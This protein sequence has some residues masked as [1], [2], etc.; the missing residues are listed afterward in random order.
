[1]DEAHALAGLG[2]CALAVG[3][4]ADAETSLRQAREIFQQ[5]GAAEALGVLAEL[6]ALTGPPRA[7]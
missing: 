1:L 2:R 7:Q 3:R 4:A 5:I 6:D